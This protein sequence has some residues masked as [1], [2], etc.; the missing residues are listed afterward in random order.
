[1]ETLFRFTLTRPPVAQDPATPSIA[2]GQ[3]SR[4]QTALADAARTE[5]PRE[6][7]RRVAR[8]FADSQDFIGEPAE[9]PFSVELAALGIALDR[10]ELD[11]K[12]AAERLAG[13]IQEAFSASADALVDTGKLDAAM[14][15]LRD[16]LIAIKQLPEEHR[17]DIEGLARRLRDLELIRRVAGDDTFPASAA[18]LRRYRRRSLA[19]PPGL[20]L[21]PILSTSKAS[22][23]Q[24]GAAAAADAKRRK[25]AE[26]LMQTYRSLRQAVNELAALG[27]EHFQATVQLA[28]AGFMP[29]LALQPIAVRSRQA[30]YV[31]KLSETALRQLQ[32]A[33]ERGNVVDPLKTQEIAGAGSATALV[34]TTLS[35]ERVLPGKPPFQPI[36]PRDGA[37]R[38]NATAIGALSDTTSATLRQRLATFTEQPLDT[39]V[40]SLE[41]EL[42]AMR[43]LLDELYAPPVQ[44]N[45]KRYGETLVM[46]TTTVPSTWTTEVTGLGG[47]QFPA[48]PLLSGS[49]PTTSGVVTLPA[50]A[51]LLVV[52]QQLV[53]YE[54][55]DIAHIENVLKGEKKL[56]EHSRRS[57]SEQLT[58][59][60]RELTTTE[61]RELESTDRFEMTR[62]TSATIREDAALKAGITISGKYGPSV[63]FSA[64]AEGSTSR[65]REEATKTA[66]SFAQEVTERSATK[67]TERVLERAQL[68][69]TNEV[70]EKNVHELNNIPGTGHISGVYQWVSKVYQA[71][72]FSYGLRTLFDFTVPEPGAFLVEVLS[73][74]HANA[75]ELQ[76]PPDFPLRPQ[77]ITEENHG[78]WVH[79]YA[80]TDVTPP[81]ERYKTKS[82]DYHAGEGEEKTDYSHS[83]QI[84]IDDGYYAVQGSVGCVI[85]VWETTWSVEVV[86]GRRPHRFAGGGSLLAVMPMDGERDSLPFA[87]NTNYVSDVAVAVEVKCQC[88]DRAIQKWQYE[89]HAKLTTAYRALLAEYE[90]KIAA[91]QVQAGVAIEGK[92]PALNQRLMRDELKKNCISILTA[93]HF[94]LFDA[95][96]PA[97]STQLAEIDLAEARA[98]GAYVRFFEHAFEWEQMTWITYPYFWGRKSE[99]TNRLSYDDPDPLFNDFLKAGFCRVSVPARPGFE[100]AIDHFLHYGELWEGAA[101]PPISGPM[102]LPIAD[103]IAERLDRPGDEV[104]VG[105]PWLVRI[106][107]TLVRLR[108]D[109]SMPS[110]SQDSVGNWVT[111]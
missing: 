89:T 99:W 47:G 2:L 12:P 39:F 85:N 58:F 80:A 11:E 51:E 111:Q 83:G 15:R 48:L 1:M 59:R 32:I 6:A 64:S 30:A 34:A 69:I 22:E 8:A 108:A 81:P 101:L 93:Q 17:R 95:V 66:S 105:E 82:L 96:N 9:T 84:T 13:A 67:V 87:L 49:I 26:E 53:G 25:R 60:E 37:F 110:W 40:S 54:A 23:E 35:A 109:D 38:L 88:S 97:P 75:L 10:L 33:S 50:Q 24:R 91:V 27:P 21:A 46:V 29:P 72:V 45:L 36:A 68:R 18:D 104:P 31:E 102:F 79:V 65:S 100:G 98:E 44:R 42:K 78:Y 71:Q 63:E 107:T 19:L 5:R 43:K 61:E 74:A 76:K 3:N 94:D 16:S 7:L 86:L 55:A 4:F 90:E 70:I 41:N 56:R 52:K 28:H 62:E 57:E 92:H 20:V 77:D 14:A 106:P 73:A 103:E